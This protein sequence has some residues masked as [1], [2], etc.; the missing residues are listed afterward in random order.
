MAQN[1]PLNTFKTF[2]FILTTVS[3]TVYTTPTGVTG[4]VLGARA[5][6]YGTTPA[7]IT[8][9]LTKNSQDYIMLNQYTIPVHDSAELVTGKL[10]LEEGCSLKA[11]IN[12][13]ETANLVL[14]VLESSNE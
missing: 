11:F 13:D 3:Q 12:E 2:P 8:F 1:L 7:T 4:I 6:N 14:S 5:S 10:I 9:I